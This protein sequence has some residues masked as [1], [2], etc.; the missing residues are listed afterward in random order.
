MQVLIKHYLVINDWN[1]KEEMHT[2]GNQTQEAFFFLME[3][4]VPLVLGAYILSLPQ[5]TSEFA[6]GRFLCKIMSLWLNDQY[7]KSI[8]AK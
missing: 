2:Y 4:K 6:C 3:K 8:R 5:F 1:Y 7:Q